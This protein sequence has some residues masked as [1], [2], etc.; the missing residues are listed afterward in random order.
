MTTTPTA[1]PEAPEHI[2]FLLVEDFSHLAYACAAEPL[3]IAN[4]VA[5]RPLYRWSLI[6]EDG[7]SATCSAG[8]EL[9]VHGGL[10]PLPRDARL[11]VVSGLGVTRRIT[12]GLL[13]FLRRERARGVEIGA[14]CSGAWVLAEAGLLEGRRAAIHWEF[15]DLMEERFP[16]VQLARSVFVSESSP[17]TAAGG[18]AASDL[19]LDLIGRRHGRAL[20]LEVAEQMLYAAAMREGDGAQRLSAQARHGLRN[21]HF[22]RAVQLMEETREEPLSCGE[23][24]AR[25]GVST[26]HLE[27]LFRAHA[28]VS[29]RRYAMDLRLERARRLLNQTE[30][31]VLEIAVACGFASASHF[32]RAYRAR[33]GV[34]PQRHRAASAPGPARA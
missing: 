33:Y 11:F 12:P 15:H 16:Q 2:A 21:R 5:G 19:M 14:I 7:Q 10:A 4:L 30:D 17:A 9:K 3:R 23:I 13:G 18:A 8:A 28:G 32:S 1:A 24:A 29:P 25:V 27:R 31:P 22:L 26:R 20:A 6:S 34:S